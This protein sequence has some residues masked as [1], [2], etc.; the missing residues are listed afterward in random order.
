MIEVEHLFKSFGAQQAVVD[1]SF[2]A[3]SGQVTGFVGPN[4][5]GKSTVMRIVAGLTTADSGVVRVDGGD[6]AQ[7][8][9]PAATMGVFL[10]SEWI[11]PAA[12]ARGVLE[13]VAE[14]QGFPHP[15]VAEA[16]DLVGLSHVAVARVGT[17][18]L[19]MRQRLGIAAA[20]L[21]RPR[22]LMLDE[23]VNGLDPEGIHW[24]RTF[25]QHAAADGATVFLSSHHMTELALIAERVVMLNRGRVVAAGPLSDIAAEETPAVYARSSDPDVVCEALAAAGYQ[26]EPARD[27]F[28]VRNAVPIDVGRIAF[29][30]GVGVSHL[31]KVS[32]SLEETYFDLLSTTER[33]PGE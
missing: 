12:T 24:F 23:P 32:A 7:S 11:P 27:G 22:I 6:F 29:A 9:R 30:T 4:G 21:G 25:L 1:V 10:S 20:T 14:S 17:F 26:T 18:S 16:L 33:E 19:G 5:A 15:R 3:P 28:L 8:D 31:E 13:Y 2:T